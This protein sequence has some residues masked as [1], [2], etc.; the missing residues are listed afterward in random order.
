MLEPLY[1][2]GNEIKGD[3]TAARIRQ[4]LSLA[5]QDFAV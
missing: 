2:L 1:E 5:A 3:E 4:R